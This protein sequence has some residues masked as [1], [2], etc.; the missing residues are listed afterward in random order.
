M[1]AVVSAAAIT[2]AGCRHQCKQ[3]CGS[4]AGCAGGACDRQH[5]KGQGGL[6]RLHEKFEQVDWEQFHPD[7]CWPEQYARES[8]RRVNA[9]FG[10][11]MNRGND[12]EM[13]VWEHYFETEKGKEAV[14]N[15]A[16]L[17]RLRYFARR[18]P[19]V[20]P[21][22]QLQ[23]SFNPELDAKRGEA[24][25]AAARKV[26]LNEFGW[27]VSVVDRAP[28]GLFGPEGPKAI[29]KMVGAAGGPPAYEPQIKRLFLSG[30]ATSSSTGGS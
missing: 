12:I 22:M 27:S 28:T 15:E 5:G 3:D 16:G 6:D 13:T 4:S 23:T 19:Y 24:L 29:T 14:L 1:L 21:V 8:K 11:Q 26:S 7:H 18:K 10:E 30:P 25:V 9:P 20:I 2:L 17:S